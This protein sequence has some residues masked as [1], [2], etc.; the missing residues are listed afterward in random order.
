MEDMLSQILNDPEKLQSA[1][2][3]A[4]SMLGGN[5]PA[6]EKGEP[7]APA[8]GLSGLPVGQPGGGGNGVYDPSAELMQKAMPVLAEIA[9]SGH[10]AVSREKLN[11]LSAVKPFVTDSVGAQIDHGL[12]LVSIARMARAAMKQ[13][14]TNSGQDGEG[15]H[16]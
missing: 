5:I 2:S 6:A 15:S 1:I 7:A 13:L 4:S 14:G 8:A 11:L 16:V 9:K 3:M 12:R 10:D